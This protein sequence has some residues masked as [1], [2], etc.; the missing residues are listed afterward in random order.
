MQNLGF[1]LCT[2]DWLALSLHLTSALQM[3]EYEKY[4][5]HT[6]IAASGLYH[7]TR[8]QLLGI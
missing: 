3:V 5:A 8:N 1:F 7:E 2:I 6:S 4:M